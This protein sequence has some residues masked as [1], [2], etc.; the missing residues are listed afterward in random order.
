[1][2]E[3][4]LKEI[5]DVH[6]NQLALKKCLKLKWSR[7]KWKYV[8]GK[9]HQHMIL[10]CQNMKTV[11]KEMILEMKVSTHDFEESTHEDSRQSENKGVDTWL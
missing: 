2:I 1:M 4:Y 5:E 7:K 10:W 3:F 9:R 6:E 11:N 8:L